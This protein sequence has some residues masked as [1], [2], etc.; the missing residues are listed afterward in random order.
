[1]G[2]Y[3]QEDTV[4][5]CMLAGQSRGVNSKIAMLHVQILAIDMSLN[6]YYARDQLPSIN[7]QQLHAC[8][9]VI[10]FRITI[11]DRQLIIP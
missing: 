5:V 11:K 3:F 10:F 9:H 6:D 1:M 2:A 7:M 8:M 4:I